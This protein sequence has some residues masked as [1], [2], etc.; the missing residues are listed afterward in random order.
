MPPMRDGM[1]RF[2]AKIVRFVEYVEPVAG[3][4]SLPLKIRGFRQAVQ[5]IC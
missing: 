5:Q 3:A 4:V 1:L 2:R